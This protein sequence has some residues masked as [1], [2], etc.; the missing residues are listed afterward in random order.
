MAAAPDKLTDV[1]N[2]THAVFAGPPLQF[3]ETAPVNPFSGV[4]VNV[5]VA[6]LPETLCD[7]GATETVKS[8][9]L[10]GTADDVLALKFESPLYVAVSVRLAAVEN[11]MA[12]DPEGALPVQLSPVLA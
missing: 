11:A 7:E 4:S 6:F 8:T 9:M 12:Q 10:T 3:S 5:Y 1:G 2:M